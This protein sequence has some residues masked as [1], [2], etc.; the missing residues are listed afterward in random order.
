MKSGALNNKK[1][2]KKSNDSF[3]E[4]GAFGNEQA[5]E[6]LTIEKLRTYD[7]FEDVDEEE[8]KEHIKLIKTFAR[9]LFDIYQQE[10]RK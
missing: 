1:T 5:K 7:G 6:E 4:N 2:T 10:N 8:A 3:S 9:V